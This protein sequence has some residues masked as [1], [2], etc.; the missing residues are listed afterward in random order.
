MQSGSSHSRRSTLQDLEDLITR[1]FTLNQSDHEASREQKVIQEVEPESS[2][3]DN[4]KHTKYHTENEHEKNPLDSMT[5]SSVQI[6]QS[7]K[8]QQSGGT[9]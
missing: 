6:Q 5:Q 2:V 8:S 1:H 3:I 9:I 4:V 7:D